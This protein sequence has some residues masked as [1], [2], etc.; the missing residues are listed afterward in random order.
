MQWEGIRAIFY[1]FLTAHLLIL[2][3]VNLH[4][5]TGDGCDQQ[6]GVKGS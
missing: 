2:P 5:S 3:E 6:D 4:E 1:F